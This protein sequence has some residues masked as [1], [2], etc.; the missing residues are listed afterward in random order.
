MNIIANTLECV[1]TLGYFF[2]FLFFA[3]FDSLTRPARRRVQ[4]PLPG[5][6]PGKLLIGEGV[7][8]LLSYCIHVNKYFEVVENFKNNT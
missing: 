7:Q 3:V 2:D 8:K 6:C 1:N 5:V 4:I